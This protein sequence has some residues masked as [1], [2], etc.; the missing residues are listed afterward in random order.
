M[1][2]LYRPPTRE[3][4]RQRWLPEMQSPPPEWSEVRPTVS[5]PFL[6][7][8]GGGRLELAEG[9]WGLVPDFHDKPLFKWQ[10]STNNARWEGD[11]KQGPAFRQTFAP[12]WW[13]GKRCL[14]P[15]DWF[16]EPSWETGRSVPWKFTAV[17][18]KPFSL[19]G[20]WNTW[21]GP[22]GEVVE[23]YTMIMI[24]AN[25]HP[26][27]GRMHEPERDKWGVPLP[28]D[29]QDKRM[30]VV[31]GA[32]NEDLWLR[33]SPDEAAALVT[34]WP[35]EIMTGQPMIAAKGGRAGRD[36]YTLDLF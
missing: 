6:R 20:L 17:D 33:G 29:Q 32:A 18:G 19:A 8:D 4:I 14:I 36:P 26:L 5:G 7:A 10:A 22:E 24:N 30:A 23:T 3:D 1:C 21:H 13:A 2:N 34:P 27:M 15:T 25:D 9:R 16:S 28:A 11:Q 31:I 35:A 12:S